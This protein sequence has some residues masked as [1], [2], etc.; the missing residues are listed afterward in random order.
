MCVCVCL[1]KIRQT[2]TSATV[3][4]LIPSNRF[5][6][7][8]QINFLPLPRV[9]RPAE[10]LCCQFLMVLLR[11]LQEAGLSQH[12]CPFFALTQQGVKWEESLT[13]WERGTRG[14]TVRTGGV[15]GSVCKVQKVCCIACVSITSMSVYSTRKQENNVSMRRKLDCFLCQFSQVRGT[16]TVGVEL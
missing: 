5:V 7:S 1:T 16:R 13:G 15:R 9:A 2:A 8:I 3:K 11:F 10:E 14:Q 12:L 6:S 4:N